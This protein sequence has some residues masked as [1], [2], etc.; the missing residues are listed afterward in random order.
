MRTL[1]RALV[2]PGILLPSDIEEA[3]LDELMELKDYFTNLA[4]HAFSA[5][6]EEFYTRLTQ[7]ET[8]LLRKL[9]PEPSADFGA[10]DAL[11]QEVSDAGK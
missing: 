10:I 2:G 6:E 9:N 7:A 8:I 3:E 11:L 5:P 4:H 1:L